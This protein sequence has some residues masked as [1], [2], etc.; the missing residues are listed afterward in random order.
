MLSYK[1]IGGISMKWVFVLH[2]PNEPKYHGKNLSNSLGQDSGV[3]GKGEEKKLVIK[4]S[5]AGVWGARCF[6]PFFAFFP[7]Y[8][9]WSRANLKA[10]KRIP[11]GGIY[12]YIYL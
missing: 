5:R 11:I 1:F 10:R 12:M 9:E 7:N 8:G 3:G 4:A 6:S 2:V